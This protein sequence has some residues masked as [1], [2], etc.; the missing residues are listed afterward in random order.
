MCNYTNVYDLKL[1][2]FFHM[3]CVEFA[4]WIQQEYRLKITSNIMNQ[5]SP[6]TVSVFKWALRPSCHSSAR[7]TAHKLYILTSVWCPK[8]NI[9]VYVTVVKAVNILLLSE[10]ILKFFDSER[11]KERIIF[12]ICGENFFFFS[13]IRF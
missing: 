6:C 5:P 9:H 3:Q 2:S 4:F 11:S 8:L 12:V 13:R 7:V 1:R 10:N